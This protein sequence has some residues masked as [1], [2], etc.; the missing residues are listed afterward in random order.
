MNV[1]FS[2]DTNIDFRQ[3]KSR[4]PIA[5]VSVLMTSTLLVQAAILVK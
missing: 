2:F 5:V 1:S 3:S 4:I